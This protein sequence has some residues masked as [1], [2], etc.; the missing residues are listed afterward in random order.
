MEVND[1]GRLAIVRLPL[2]DANAFELWKL[3]DAYVRAKGLKR[4]RS[5]GANR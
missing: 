4:I 1:T 3:L 2:S 5:S